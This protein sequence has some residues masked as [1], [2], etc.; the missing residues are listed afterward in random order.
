MTTEIEQEPLRIVRIRVTDFMRLEAI[1]ITPGDEPVIEV[2]GKNEQ[3]KSC[4][5]TAIR[6]VLGGAKSRPEV[7]VRLGAE[8]AEVQLDIGRRDQEI[9]FT[10]N[11]RCRPGK[12][13]ELDVRSANGAPVPKAQGFLDRLI[14][15][16]MAFDPLEFAK[17]KPADQVE[18]LKKLA[19]LDFS[20][21][22]ADHDAVYAKR[23]DVNREADRLKTRAEGI[24]YVATA[25]DEPVSVDDLLERQKKALAEERAFEAAQR[26]EAAAREA[27][28]RAQKRVV[29]AREELARAEVAL[30][31]AQEDE[32]D[33]AA[34][35][36]ATSKPNVAAISEQLKNAAATNEQ[37]RKKKERADLFAQYRAKAD[38]SEALSAK[39]EGIKTKKKELLAAAK[40][41]VPG[42]S[43][44]DDK[45]TLN[46]LPLSQASGAQTLRVSLAV[47]LAQEPRLKLLISMGG[48]LCDSESMA[49][50]REMFRTAGGQLWIETPTDGEVT[51]DPGTL[52]ISE[53][54]VKQAAA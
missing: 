52:V 9:E 50:V 34:A 29:A 37:V 21:L 2:Q 17:A 19:G 12:D 8:Q 13:D 42:L 46:G 27:V 49:I 4:L 51:G 20:Q 14:G 36:M 24:Q 6:S 28:D 48:K 45:V 41:P 1:D 15:N 31:A 10:A 25:P 26:A 30:T 38:E 23:T 32:T 3:G 53:G 16:R 7:P 35:A 54:T 22:N 40:F 18:T 44:E 33:K 5:L 11:L 39:I 43:F 47:V